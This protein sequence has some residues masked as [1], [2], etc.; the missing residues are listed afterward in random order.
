[1]KITYLLTTADAVGG[2]ERAV[3]NQASELAGRHDVRV[4]SVF[5]SRREQFFTPHERVRLDYLVDLASGTPRPFRATGMDES[6]RTE[7][8]TQPSRIV[9]RSWEAAFS[10]LSDLELELALQTTDTDVL[11]TTTP[12][13]MALAVELAP[14]RVITV[15]QEHRVSE[16]RGTSGEPLRRYTPRLD[17]LAVLSE[18]TRDW[19]AETLAG[20]APRLEVVPNALPGGFRPRSTLQT[21]TVVI[22]AASSRRSRSTTP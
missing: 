5:K 15:H 20:A 16:L 12:A 11:V 21:R 19:F 6:V 18:R 9:D 22:A 3:F 13:L 8:A 4:L 10:R 14:A 1:M 17:A 7:L 2:T